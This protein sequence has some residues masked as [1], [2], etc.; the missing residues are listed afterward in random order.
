MSEASPH[1]LDSEAA[2]ADRLMAR[3]ANSAIGCVFAQ[4]DHVATLA[5]SRTMSV[6]GGLSDRLYQADEIRDELR[7]MGARLLFSDCAMMAPF[8][9]TQPPLYDAI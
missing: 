3:V 7:N 6:G 1:G 4:A 9:V 8:D 2:P 5:E